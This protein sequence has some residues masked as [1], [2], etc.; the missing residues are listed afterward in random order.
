M[1]PPNHST[2]LQ[3]SKHKRVIQMINYYPEFRNQN[4]LNNFNNFPTN[5]I[6]TYYNNLSTR[7]INSNF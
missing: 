2:F 1:S 5:S 4:K 6:K 7:L 3:I